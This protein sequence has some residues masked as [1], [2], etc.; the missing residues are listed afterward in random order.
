[1]SPSL[2]LGC[3]SASSTDEALVA[4][5]HF[6]GLDTPGLAYDTS[7]FGE[8]AELVEPP[9]PPIELAATE[10]SLAVPGSSNKNPKKSLELFN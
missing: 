10:R 3:L 4:Q 9:R 8:I 5:G 6:G 2:F 1:M 7:S